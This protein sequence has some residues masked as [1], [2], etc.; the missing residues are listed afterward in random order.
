MLRIILI[1]FAI[2]LTTGSCYYDKEEV[3]YPGSANC[4]VPATPGFNADIMPILNSRCNSCHSG[5]APSA[6]ISLANYTEVKKSVNNGSLIG[7]IT[8]ASGF[9]PMPK[10]SGKMPSCEIQKIQTWIDQGALNN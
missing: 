2:I 8:W 6:G 10:N 5:V 1:S 7:S 4:T 9:S 3:L